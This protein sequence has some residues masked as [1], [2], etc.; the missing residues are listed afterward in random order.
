MTSTFS[1]YSSSFGGGAAW[2]LSCSDLYSC[3]G[4]LS[5]EPSLKLLL[6]VEISSGTF[7][8]PNDGRSYLGRYSEY[9]ELRTSTT[10]VRKTM[11]VKTAS[12]RGD[13]KGESSIL[14][15]ECEQRGLLCL[16]VVGNARC[17]SR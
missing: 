5:P 3:H 8:L 16:V 15:A 12:R 10:I 11:T 7:A 1:S 17:S 2:T 14:P 6:P 4:S 9:V 13:P